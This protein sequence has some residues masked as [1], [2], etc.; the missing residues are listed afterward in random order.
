MR[1]Y[2]H[3]EVRALRWFV[4]TVVGM[5]AP[6]GS[7]Y[8]ETMAD[9]KSVPPLV[10]VTGATG[11]PNILM[12]LDNSNSMDEADTGAAVGSDSASS[13]S[14]I[15]RN[16]LK[17]MITNFGSS[18][19]MGLMAYKQS[20]ISRRELHDSQYD[21]SFNPANYDPAFTGSI[22]STTKR[23]R[24]P[25]VS[26][27]GQYVYYNV[28]LP[29]YS[30]GN[31]GSAYCFTNDT[32]IFPDPGVATR[33][34]NE[35][36]NCYG[37]KTNTSD[38]TSGFGSYKFGGRFSPT[39]SDIAQG[40]YDFGKFLT[41]NHVGQ[42][43]F[44]NSSPGKGM[45]HVE[46]A[47]VDATQQAALFNKLAT[48]QFVSAIDTPLRNAGLTPLEGTLQS[49]KD[50]YM[51]TLAAGESVSGSVPLP[52]ASGSCGLEDYVVL[53]TDGLPSTTASGANVADTATGVSAVA[54]AAADL[55]ADAGVR[56]YVV[57]FALPTGVDAT[58]LDQVA[59]SG[60]TGTAYL[61]S[62]TASLNAALG[63][64]FLNI[65][66]RTS[67]ATGAAVLANNASGDGS[68]FQA[69][70][71]P[72]TEDLAGNTVTW[73][74][75]LSALFI[76]SNG[77]LREDT[78]QNGKIDNYASDMSIVYY[79]DEIQGRTLANL[80]AGTG[81]T[82][83]DTSGA[84]VRT[85]ELSELSAVWKA[86]DQLSALTNVTTQR[87]YTTSAD[88]GRHILTTVD[89]VNTIDFSEAEVTTNVA[90]QSH[91]MLGGASTIDM[92]NYIRGEEIA[93][94]RARVLDTDNDG[95]TEVQRLG[96]IVHSTPASVRVPNGS[97][98][99]KNKDKTYA[100]FRERY[101]NRRQM[102][103]VGANDGMIHA[104]NSGFWDDSDKEYSTSYSGETA[105]PLGSELWAYIPRTSLPH[106]QWLKD[107]G[108]EH[109]Y[110]VDGDPI[111]FDANIFSTDTDHPYGW[112]TVLVIGMRLGG[113]TFNVDTNGDGSA[114]TPLRS[115]YIL[116]DVTNPEKPPSLIAEI[117][118]VDLGYTTGVP[119]VVK[120]RTATLENDYTSTSSNDWML[121]FGSGPTEL[122]DVTSTQEPTVY[123][124]DLVAKAINTQVSIS[125][126][127][128]AFIGSVSAI[129]WGDDLDD[130]IAYFGIVAGTPASP[131]G[132]VMRMK[133]DTD[134]LT[135][136]LTPDG[137]STLIDT[138][139]PT[140]AKPHLSVDGLGRAW[141]HFGTGRILDEDDNTSVEQQRY[142]GVIEDVAYAEVSPSDLFDSSN[143]RVF[144]DGSVNRGGSAFDLPTGTS[145]T[146]F[147]QLA[148]AIPSEKSGWYRDLTYSLLDPSGRN[149]TASAQ[150]RTI[151]FFTE[152]TP[153]NSSCEPEG[154][155]KLFGVDYRT[156]TALPFV[157][158]DTDPS[159][160]NAAAELSNVSLDL[161]R[162]MAS[163]P[164]ILGVQNKVLVQKSTSET[165]IIDVN[166]GTTVSGR[167]TWREI[168]L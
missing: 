147:T 126:F 109:V 30:G 113:G 49:A 25:N 63:S 91:L 90:L 57:G 160:T 47:D 73:T 68:I 50:Y 41:W 44:A 27:P 97:Y 58:L 10:D 121:V 159:I 15:A 152:Y 24:V 18:S 9:F 115:S 38:N 78:N 35:L 88:Q 110:Y 111:V 34:T 37:T 52:P 74:G 135:T 166:L 116:L 124:Y 55:Y 144:E 40:I 75:A 128:D 11:K 100:A 1:N 143:I 161:G 17:T 163:A 165:S 53:V 167:Q 129:D 6:F 149:T 136:R 106:L 48:S 132:G 20:G 33:S 117:S 46:V 61:A 62:D 102:V 3:F 5:V 21:A 26:N 141:V 127:G 158:F 130:D 77:Y 32:T 94:Y 64:I 72:E 151:V 168:K 133:F 80:Y 139:R 108:Y 42:T 162:G 114:D 31:N 112:G 39:D 134:P 99:T 164:I 76:D 155:S 16:A 107:G 36:Y 87:G 70:Y 92:V 122:S 45:L 146:S 66:N 101:K 84:A 51:G 150:A 120:K 86:E 4:F 98:D 85:V 148:S 105:H 23:Y 28:S 71:S 154:T 89:G 118:D 156:G 140:Y 93:G 157:V 125:D 104:F 7:G 60:Q 2:F 103:Y 137:V 54:Q 14:E 153:S 22:A 123:L 96:D 145:I 67:S 56:T 95:T 13:K 29:F 131:T 119:A 19:R 83:P 69:L 43:W 79:Y 12:I 65:I 82:P 8:A 59:A 142:Y 138:G 81:T